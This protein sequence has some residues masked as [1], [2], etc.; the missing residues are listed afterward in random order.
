MCQP[1]PSNKP[2]DQHLFSLIAVR[3]D[4]ID[5]EESDDDEA[6]AAEAEDTPPRHESH[7][8]NRS[9]SDSVPPSRKSAR[10]SEQQNRG[11]EGRGAEGENRARSFEMGGASEII[12][13]P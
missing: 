1:I 10:I 7:R 11:G 4:W 12:G 8:R 6:E 5:D 3:L 2:E 9:P 13:A